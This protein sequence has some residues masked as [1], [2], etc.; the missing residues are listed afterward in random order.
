MTSVADKGS[1][2]TSGC[3]DGP[4]AAPRC[5]LRFAMPQRPVYRQVV[6]AHPPGTE[7]FF[8]DP[9]AGPAVERAD[10]P[11]R[12]HRRIE[13]VDD[14]ACPALFDDLRNGSG[15]VSDDRSSTGQRLDHHQ[16]ER[17]GPVDREQLRAGATEERGLLRLADLA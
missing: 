10:A 13:V 12:P 4:D 11:H 1:D 8:E 6:S 3:R 16:P 14:V 2:S 7:A 15:A 9:A 5:Q 17:F